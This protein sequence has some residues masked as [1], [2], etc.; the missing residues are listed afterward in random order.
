MALKVLL[1][2]RPGSGKTTAAHYLLK[3]AGEHGLSARHID[4]YPILE[5]KFRADQQQRR[6]R[7]LIVKGACCGFDVLDFSVLDEVL[8]E[9]EVRVEEHIALHP[10]DGLALLEFARD[11]YRHAFAQFRPGFLRDAAILYCR[12]DPEVSLQRVRE[13]YGKTGYQLVSEHILLDYY[14]R[15]SFCS[16]IDDLQKSF[17]IY[18]AIDIC[19]N[20]GSWQAFFQHLQ[21]FF[22]L[23]LEREAGLA[24]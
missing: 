22:L 12:V 10:S 11:D 6:F 19:D 14:R 3:L 17:G 1:L 18:R 7:P 13:R 5:E 15:D 23:L 9:A 20:N 16:Q 4:D 2:G 24:C 21:Q 8:A